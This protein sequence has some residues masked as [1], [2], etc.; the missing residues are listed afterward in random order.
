[1]LVSDRPRLQRGSTESIDP[2]DMMGPNAGS[3][4]QVHGWPADPDNECKAMLVSAM[5]VRPWLIQAGRGS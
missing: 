5:G 3:A 1:M 2:V 4:D